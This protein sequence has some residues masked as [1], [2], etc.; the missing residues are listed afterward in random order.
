MD[1]YLYLKSDESDNYFATNQVYSFKIHLKVPLYFTGTWR[2]GLLELHAQKAKGR[3]S[4]GDDSIYVFS[5]ICK[6]SIVNGVEK[7]ILRRLERSDKNGWNYVFNSPIYVPLKRTE[8]IEFEI[9]I[10]TEDG[11]FATFLESPIYLTLHFK[12]YPFYVDIDSF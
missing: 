1:R 8:L 5:N 4:K 6:D 7:P 3:Q 9:Y 11:T 12:R 10:K 2:V